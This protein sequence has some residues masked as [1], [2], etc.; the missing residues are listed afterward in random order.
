MANV[1]VVDDEA[2]LRA[3]MRATLEPPHAV[4]EAE[5]AAVA[6]AAVR[7]ERPDVVI[8]DVML[9]GTSGIDV[10]RELR[11]DSDLAAIPVVVVSAWD[12]EEDRRRIDEVGADAFVAKPFLP[13][14]LLATVER[15]LRRGEP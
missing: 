2:P 13:E 1:L 3:L 6:L 5:D 12:A 11:T 4:T 8:L 14:E 15:V 10:L 7:A 9:P